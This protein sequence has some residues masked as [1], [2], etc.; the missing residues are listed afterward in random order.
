MNTTTDIQ[1]KE[2]LAHWFQLGKQLINP[3]T[4]EI[5]L[6]QPIYQNGQYSLSFEQTW[7]YITNPKNGDFYLEG[8][9]QNIQ[10]LFSPEWEL[11]SCARCSLPIPVRQSGNQSLI[12]PCHDIDSWPNTKLPQPRRGID[13][14]H[15]LRQLGDRLRQQKIAQDTCDR[16]QEQKIIA[17]DTCDRLWQEHNKQSP[18]RN[19]YTGKKPE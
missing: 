4:G 7:R 3:K 12:C 8:M 15:H 14:N 6:P 11:V 18:E 9:P 10:D 17:Q 2:Y 16:L 1:V 5:I 13:S 19:D